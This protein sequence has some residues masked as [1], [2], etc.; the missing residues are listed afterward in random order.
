MVQSERKRTK[1]RLHSGD[2]RLLDVYYFDYVFLHERLLVP[3]QRK[4][5]SLKTPTLLLPLVRTHNELSTLK[6]TKQDTD[7]PFNDIKLL[8]GKHHVV[9]VKKTTTRYGRRCLDIIVT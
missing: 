4:I 7:N 3:I 8:D 1:D 9:H 2:L 5:I 6:Q